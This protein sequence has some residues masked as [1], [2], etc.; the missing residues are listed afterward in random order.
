MSIGK[1]VV[2]VDGAIYTG[3]SNM[4]PIRSNSYK[5][6]NVINTSEGSYLGV[7]PTVVTTPLMT[8][9]KA[10][11]V[12]TSA[13][14]FILA[15]GPEP[16]YDGENNDFYEM[17]QSVLIQ[18]KSN[19]FESQDEW[20][21]YINNMF[22]LNTDYYDHAFDV[23]A[24]FLPQELAALGGLSHAMH[25]NI[26]PSYNFYIE[27]YE[28]MT[29][30]NSKIPESVM[31]NMYAFMFEK[32]SEYLDSDNSIYNQL[33]TLNGAIPDVYKDVLNKSGKKIGEEDEGQYYEKYARFYSRAARNKEPF[34]SL[35][36]K[37]RNIA[38]PVEDVHKVHEYNEMAEMF[39]MSV[40]VEFK[41]DSTTTFAELL[42][43]AGLCSDLTNEIVVKNIR[44]NFANLQSHQSVEVA[45]Q[46]NTSTGGSVVRRNTNNNASQ[47]RMMDVLSWWSKYANVGTQQPL[48]DIADI[49]YF[50]NGEKT[51][52][53]TAEEK[54]KKNLLMLI[55]AGKL[56]SLIKQQLR[57]YQ[58]ML[59]GD[60][61]HSETVMYRIAKFKGRRAVGTPVQN[62]FVA[63]SNDID[64]VKYI[65]TQVKFN[66]QYTYKVY[67]YQFVIGSR[68]K[69][70]NLNITEQ[71]EK[72]AGLATEFRTVG[73]EQTYRATFDVR[74]Y[75]SIKLIEVPYFHESEV[76]IDD[77][78]VPPD[79]EILPYRGINNRLLMNFNSNVGEYLLDPIVINN[80]EQ[81]IVDRIRKAQKRPVGPIRY[82]SDDH[83]KYFEVFRIEHHPH[84]YDDYKNKRVALVHTDISL[85]TK[86]K[87]S[88]AAYKERLSPNKKYYYMFRSIDIHGKI[89]NPTPI[90]QVEIVD[91]NGLIFPI[92]KTVDFLEP[93][94]T[95]PSKGMTRYLYVAPRYTQT[96]LNNE[97][98]GL[99]DAESATD[100][101]QY[102]LGLQDESLWGKR[103][104]IRLTSKSTGKKM[105]INVDFTHEHIVTTADEQT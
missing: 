101:T 67:A 42:R 37:Y 96:I 34:N 54:Y 5:Y 66:N 22:V 52:A 61:C 10:A 27:P 45:S 98:S 4:D 104:K 59:S 95:Q 75:P 73:L 60:M 51:M 55:F 89:S 53:L 35:I 97:K 31:P 23:D 103:F 102:T 80:E 68:Y 16:E 87:A 76:L 1:K 25:A 57:T 90:Y 21:E 79:I 40:D 8:E 92:I 32:N 41:T 99:T 100:A 74:T 49:A 78:P 64:V 71:V 86:K 72:A 46:Q 81:L 77:P 48:P 13:C 28:K 91:D 17:K 18:A 6:W 93:M 88:S 36:K 15:L 50:T 2:I 26:E 3:A 43:E 82:K 105:D 70:E 56:R 24:P 84:S 7:T 20:E 94:A 19:Q 29:G 63:N 11:N 38:I 33:I 69:Y 83:A 30:G 47:H 12:T 65:D 14:R 9:E 58:Q 62:I 39:P 85:K 44:N